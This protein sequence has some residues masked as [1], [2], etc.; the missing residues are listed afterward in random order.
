MSYKDYKYFTGIG[1]REV[2][3]NVYQNMVKCGHWLSRLGY[4]LRSGKAAGSDT[5]FQIGVEDY[6][7][8]YSVETEHE[9][10]IPWKTFTG[11]VGT[12]SAHDI[13]TYPKDLEEQAISIARSIHTAWDAVRKDGTPVLG[14]GAKNYI[15]VIYF[16]Y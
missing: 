6:A 4:R 10:Y 7:R 2:P 15:C 5:A 11:G 14:Q 3:N 13:Y 12:N 1:S 8:E 9:I 16:R